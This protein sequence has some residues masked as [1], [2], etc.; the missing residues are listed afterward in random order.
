[1]DLEK[2]NK[3]ECKKCGHACHCLDDFHSDVYGLCS[4]DPCECN[5]PKNQGEECLSCQ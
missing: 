1:M 3:N 2:K 4:C 5:D